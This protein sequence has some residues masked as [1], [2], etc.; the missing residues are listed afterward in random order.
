MNWEQV[1]GNWHQMKGRVKQKWGELTDDELDQIAGRR[2]YLAGKIQKT[3]GIT[4]EEAEKQVD[5]W[6]EKEKTESS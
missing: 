3:Y 1:R 6:L 5:E 4:L 2:E